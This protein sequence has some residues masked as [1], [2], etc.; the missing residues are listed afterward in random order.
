MA[1]AIMDMKNYGNENTNNMTTS[2]WL[3]QV[4]SNGVI[5]ANSETIQNGN[6]TL[7]GS[8]INDLIGNGTAD[9]KLVIRGD[10]KF[11]DTTFNLL[12]QLTRDELALKKEK[13][14]MVVVV[15]E[16]NKIFEKSAGT[17]L[18][19]ELSKDYEDTG[20]IMDKNDV[21]IVYDEKKP[22]A[23]ASTIYA[24]VPFVGS[25]STIYY[26]PY[27]NYNTTLMRKK[28]MDGGDTSAINVLSHEAIHSYDFKLGV[29]NPYK[30]PLGHVPESEYRTVGLGI[31]KNFPIT[32]NKIRIEQGFNLRIW[33]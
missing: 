10:K 6:K 22:R 5:Y 19:R 28:I 13:D 29:S 23:E 14:G 20:K 30:S 27:A 17:E 31:Y 2:Q 21:V 9:E 7:M 11:T 24:T 26:N 15:K 32:E 33:Y 25:G 12:Q 8:L 1:S 18:I 4:G 3:N 16:N